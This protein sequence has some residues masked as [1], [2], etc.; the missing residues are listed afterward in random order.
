M[1]EKFKNNDLRRIGLKE[2]TTGG[3][4]EAAK[5]ELNTDQPTGHKLWESAARG[6][7]RAFKGMETI[8]GQL[9]NGQTDPT[10]FIKKFDPQ[11]TSGSIP[12]GLDIMNRMLNVARN[13]SLQP[14]INPLGTILG[15]SLYGQLTSFMGSF[16]AGSKGSKGGNEKKDNDDNDN[17]ELYIDP[18]IVQLVKAVLK[19]LNNDDAEEQ[20]DLL[21][22]N[23]YYNIQQSYLK[24]RNYT[25][26]RMSSE[27]V[28]IVNNLIPIFRRSQGIV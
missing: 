21:N 27:F 17:K 15:G 28:R 22:S 2:I 8:G 13:P 1:S 10:K 18:L 5:K 9:W 23:E 24:G 3:W 6:G 12:E 16:G 20:S 26:T 4:F 25:S 11:N 14:G 19:Q 7:K